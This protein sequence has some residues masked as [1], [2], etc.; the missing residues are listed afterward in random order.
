[1]YRLGPNDNSFS[2]TETLRLAQD[3]SARVVN[4]ETQSDMTLHTENH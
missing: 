1:M 3:I 2:L 4:A